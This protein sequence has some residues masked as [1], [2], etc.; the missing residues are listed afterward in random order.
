MRV[1]RD[2]LRLYKCDLC[3]REFS[4]FDDKQYSRVSLCNQEY[5]ES[6]DCC[7]RCTKF[8]RSVVD[9]IDNGYEPYISYR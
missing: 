4:E 6:Y 1:K 9:L 3:R 5:T 2:N 8:I 7:P